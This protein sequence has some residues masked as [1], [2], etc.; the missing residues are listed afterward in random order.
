[1]YPRLQ[2][3][4]CPHVAA[5]TTRGA[6]HPMPERCAWAE[7]SPLSLDYHDREWGVPQRDDR[8]LFE[9]LIL[10]GAQAG[11]SWETSCA[12]A[13]P[14]APPSTPSTRRPSPLRHAEDHGADGRRGHRPQPAQD[15]GGHPERVR[16]PRRARRARHFLHLYLELRR[17]RPPPAYLAH[18]PPKCPPPARHPT[19]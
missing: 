4:L 15:R 3:A 12:S 7:G 16:L 1:M 5:I 2:P 13:P 9:L 18:P 17:W 6:T 8:H 10:Q 14:T 19:P 11:L